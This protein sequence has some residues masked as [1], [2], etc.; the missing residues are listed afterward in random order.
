MA[1]AQKVYDDDS[2]EPVTRPNLRALEGG[3][4][5]TSSK[6]GHVQ[7]A[8]N[9]DTAS[10]SATA[11]DIKAQEETADESAVSEEDDNSSSATGNGKFT[12]RHEG[13]HKKRS[14]KASRRFFLLVGGGAGILIAGILLLFLLA[15]SLKSIHFATVL[16]GSG[17]ATTQLVMRKTFSDIAFDAS[18]L[19]EGNIGRPGKTGRTMFDRIRGINP[20]KVVQNL[21]KE[22]RFAL[23][24]NGSGEV[25]G[26]RIDDQVV[27]VNKLAQERFS[28]KNFDQL[29]WREKL[30]VKNVT[31]DEFNVKMA[32]IFEAE[33]SSYRTGF[34][35]AFRNYFDINTSGLATKLREFFG[36]S[37][38]EAYKLAREY[39]VDNINQGS[40][41]QSSLDQVNEGT[42]EYRAAEKEAVSRN[43]NQ[44]TS[45]WTKTAFEKAGITDIAQFSE[46]ASKVSTA[47]FAMTIYCTAR[48]LDQSITNINARKEVQAQRVA[49]QSQTFA[50]EIK[51][52][53]VNAAAV[54]AEARQWD[55]GG[56][57]P[58]ATASPFYREATGRDPTKASMAAQD[59]IPTARIGETPIHDVF[60]VLDGAL[61]GYLAGN[62]PGL[63][64]LRDAV[65]DEACPVV[66]DP[67]TMTAVAGGDTAISIAV[68]AATGGL[69]EA[70]KEGVKSAV[71]LSLG[72]YG[73]NLIGQWLDQL[74][75]GY[76][77]ADFSGARTGVDKYN[78]AAVATN[79]MNANMG[80]GNAYGRPEN[81]DEAQASQK[82]AMA[83]MKNKYESSSMF[84]RYFAIDNPFSLIGNVAATTPSSFGALV[85]RAQDGI[86]S[87]GSGLLTM[88]QSN[89]ILGSLVSSVFGSHVSA[90]SSQ[91][92][93]ASHNYFG[94]HQWGWT[95]DELT[96]I[97]NDDSFQAIPNADW[98]DANVPQD[99]QSKFQECYTPQEQTKVPDFCTKDFLGG[100]QAL[101]WRLYKLQNAVIDQLTNMNKI[102][103]DDNSQPEAPPTGLVAGCPARA[104]LQQEILTSPNI[105]FQSNNPRGD[106]S[107][108]QLA[109]DDILCIVWNIAV[110]NNMTI[111]ISVF[112]TGHGGCPGGPSNHCRGF[113][114]DIGSSGTP[115]LPAVFRYVFANRDALQINELIY[116]PVPSSPAGM[117]TL[118]QG[119]CGTYD[120]STLAEH[121]DHVHIAVKGAGSR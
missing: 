41:A 85:P 37:P 27:D 6:R 117:C 112:N 108:P 86:M 69:T 110:K 53:K 73:G 63:G 116:N 26:F 82:L 65:I 99:L 3:G 42:E 11:D 4:A 101:H 13:P 1:Q 55:G 17:F 113:A 92:F 80:R 30:T 51:E 106:V 44:R 71:V 32:D 8:D 84:E 2:P 47:V 103:A 105:H 46:A 97:S 18:V 10:K 12:Y 70:V 45:D 36:K 95:N 9:S 78:S 96:R 59:G 91:S 29:S 75:R 81:T 52:H 90:A 16:R 107:N 43:L 38:D 33:S 50:D 89:G 88:F 35:K 34:M 93:M 98:V 68:A 120:G 7:S 48:D 77:G 15:G 20:D 104:Q 57:V 31:L 74:V 21:A 94:V 102:T 61:G 39:D 111:G 56:D 67:I 119:V 22:D 25:I 54:G 72:I 100:N 62:I 118:K 121:R 64:E 49:H 115:D 28:G 79:Y 19:D 23:R 114:V 76:A 24:T 66:L 58:P 14:S 40:F 5:L 60:S 87:L 83:D 109:G